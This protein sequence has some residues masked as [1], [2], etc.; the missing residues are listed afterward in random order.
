MN[1]PLAIESALKQY[2]MYI[3]FMYYEKLPVNFRKNNT[4]KREK[5]GEEK[6]S[7]GEKI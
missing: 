3:F 6:L 5:I 4:H 2:S 7:F 1:K